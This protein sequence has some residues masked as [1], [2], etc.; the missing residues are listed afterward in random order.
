MPGRSTSRNWAENHRVDVRRTG[1][2]LTS[3]TSTRCAQAT[4]PAAFTG[5]DSRAESTGRSTVGARNA[6]LLRGSA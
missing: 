1:A 5:L 4:G 2:A 3:A 6:S